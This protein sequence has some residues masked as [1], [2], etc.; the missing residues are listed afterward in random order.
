MNGRRYPVW[1][2][3]GLAMFLGVAPTFLAFRG[4]GEAGL[5]TMRPFLKGHVASLDDR[6]W[7]DEERTWETTVR[8]TLLSIGARLEGGKVVD[9]TGK[10]LYFLWATEFTGAYSDEKRR[11]VEERIRTLESEYHLI[12][13]YIGPRM[14]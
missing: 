10:E 7:V 4:C 11:K 3:L 9:P 6:Y 14:P 2:L 8:Q 1:A 12:R 5:Q 13:M